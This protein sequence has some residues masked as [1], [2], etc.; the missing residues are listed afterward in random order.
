MSVETSERRVILG[1][2]VLLHEVVK[3]YLM[4]VIVGEVDDVMNDAVE[5][6]E[7]IAVT[8]HLDHFRAVAPNLYQS[9]TQRSP[10][11]YYDCGCG[12]GDAGAQV[13]WDA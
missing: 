11:C 3:K 9:P 12:C 6:M 4:D 8:F 5:E 10:G 1:V 13:C 2:C 7:R